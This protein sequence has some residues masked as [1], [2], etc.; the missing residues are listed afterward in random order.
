MN[1]QRE[2][3]ILIA[4]KVAKEYS[5]LP[6]IESI[7]I[8]GSLARGFADENSDAEMYVYYRKKMP[9]KNEIRAILGRLTAK[10]TRS[11]NPH[12]HHDAWG[13]HTF[14]E[15]DGVKFELGYRYCKEIKSRMNKFV[16][17]LIL[18]KHGL[19]D[20]PFGHYES[21]V[22]NCIKSCK[23]LIDKK[24]YIANLKKYLSSYP[25][26]I[27]KDTFDYY[28]SDA[29]TLTN[30]K[31]KQ[32]IE[33][34]D[35]FLFHACLSR[36]I[37]SII[38]VMFSLNKVYYPG[39]KWNNKYITKFKMKPSGFDADIKHIFEIPITGNKNKKDIY[40]LLKRIMEKIENMP[41]HLK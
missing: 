35:D 18:P 12:W 32:A 26:K 8:G 30:I 31:L 11:N 10:L 19:F 21:G 39:D 5:S 23:I 7:V 3:L 9:S 34:N 22:A 38:L 33:R 27:R 15:V 20:T 28:F 16:K 37:R 29:K 24:A 36:I 1:K 6:Q 2:K 41:H 40:F 14:F 13:Y 17:S 4:K 25:S